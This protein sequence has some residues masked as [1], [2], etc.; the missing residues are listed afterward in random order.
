MK[1]YDE[2]TKN[3]LERRDSYNTHKK[4]QKKKIISIIVP[5]CCITLVTSLVLGVMR[6]DSLKDS[7]Q[8]AVDEQTQGEKAENDVSDNSNKVNKEN[9]ETTK[10]VNKGNKGKKPDKNNSKNDDEV[11]SGELTNTEN[12][13]MPDLG[14]E[15]LPDKLHDNNKDQDKEF[16][17][18][19]T[20][21]ESMKMIQKIVVTQMPVKTVYYPGDKFDY[22]GLEVTGYFSTGEVEDITPYVQIY[23]TIAYGVSDDYRIYIEYTDN[24]EAINLAYTE[25]SLKVIEPSL[26]ITKKSI[27]LNVG[28]SADNS[29]ITEAKGCNITWHSTDSSVVKVD[30][31]GNI[32]AVG[33]GSASVYAEIS[34]YYNS[35]DCCFKKVSPYCSVT[36]N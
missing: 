31:D 10:K 32:T 19:Q 35:G 4:E 30:N 6:G 23:N 5:V 26:D 1:N 21:T 14:L 18:N 25:F 3:L 29:V 12:A 22:R 33:S 24:S 34:Y 13:L 8:I 27:N 28:E 15:E 17:E 36:V 7:L 9:T 11:V 20:T 16:L 2:I